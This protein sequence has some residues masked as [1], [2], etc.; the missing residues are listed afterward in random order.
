MRGAADARGDAGGRPHL[1]SPGAAPLRA[2]VLR[3]GAGVG[4]RA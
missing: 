4:P 3:T 2:A 1:S